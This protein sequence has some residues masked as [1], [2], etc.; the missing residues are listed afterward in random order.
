MKNLF[1]STFGSDMIKITFNNFE[2]TNF[3][4]GVESSVIIHSNPEIDKFYCN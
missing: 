2:F 1:S 4:K 3:L